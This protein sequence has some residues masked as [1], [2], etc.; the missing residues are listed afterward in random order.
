MREAIHVAA[1][2]QGTTSTRCMIFNHAGA[3]IVGY[4]KEHTQIY[5]RPGSLEWGGFRL[6]RVKFSIDFIDSN[7]SSTGQF[8]SPVLGPLYAQPGHREGAA[9]L[10]AQPAAFTHYRDQ[11]STEDR[12]WRACRRGVATS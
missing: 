2:D 4:Q 7:P 8:Q 3:V 12:G 6:D 1:I 9:P 5:P 11:T 10:V